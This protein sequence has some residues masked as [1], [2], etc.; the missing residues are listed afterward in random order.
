ME[1]TCAKHAFRVRACRFSVRS[2]SFLDVF[3]FLLRPAQ[4]NVRSI[5]TKHALPNQAISDFILIRS[6]SMTS[7]RFLGVR[8]RTFVCCFAFI[9]F[10]CLFARHVKCKPPPEVWFANA[11]GHFP[12][13]PAR[14]GTPKLRLQ[15]PPNTG[16]DAPETSSQ[17]SNGNSP[18]PLDVRVENASDSFFDLPR[19]L[20]DA[21]FDLL[22]TTRTIIGVI[23][24]NHILVR[25]EGVVD[26]VIENAAPKVGDDM[27]QFW[28][29]YD[30]ILVVYKSFLR[31]C[32]IAKDG[33]EVV[34]ERTIPAGASYYHFSFRGARNRPTVLRLIELAAYGAE[35][36]MMEKE[37]ADIEKSKH[38]IVNSMT[39][40]LFTPLMV[41]DTSVDEISKDI[42]RLRVAFNVHEETIEAYLQAQISLTQTN[43]GM[44]HLHE[45][46]KARN[47]LQEINKRIDRFA[48]GF[49]VHLRTVSTQTAELRQKILNMLA[50]SDICANKFSI[51]MKDKVNL[52]EL[53]NDAHLVF[54]P[55]ALR[56]GVELETSLDAGQFN[57]YI[58][59]DAVRFK[60]AL[61]AVLQN[62]VQFSY[63]N[64][65]PIRFDFQMDEAGGILFTVTDFGCGI[66]KDHINMVCEAFFAHHPLRANEQ[67]LG[68]GLFLTRTF[69]EAMGGQLKVESEEGVST[70]V[71]I[72][73]PLRLIAT[74]RV[75]YRSTKPECDPRRKS[76]FEPRMTD[77]AVAAAAPHADALATLMGFTVPANG[78]PAQEQQHSVKTYSEM[79]EMYDTVL[80]SE[81]NA[82]AGKALKRF[83]E[84]EGYK[85]E[86]Y[87]T[88][89]EALTRFRDM[90]TKFFAACLDHFTP[91]S[92]LTGA[93]I[94]AALQKIDAKL[95][96]VIITANVNEKVRQD[97]SDAGI[98]YFMEKPFNRQLLA[99]WLKDFSERRMLKE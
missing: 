58:Q 19:L 91:P 4:R 85:T 14:F 78:P 8:A 10:V 43:D 69:V 94:G 45:V 76:L 67:S 31:H 96:I 66:S 89:E 53:C 57:P 95:P 87:K 28:A 42:R 1:W 39:H 15:G 98:E 75:Q 79:M 6:E 37:K 23:D 92:A 9:S 27:L 22:A 13:P 88:G 70:R 20:Q 59:I 62:A 54:G 34:A 50:Y 83:I 93:E 5:K 60:Q 82:I 99:S 84:K 61:F 18:F 63:E 36:A 47:S 65:Q 74:H 72:T 24:T 2:E 11:V 64:G 90:P 35:Q 97:V 33:E 56:K 40:N 16:S 68:L 49:D 7:L 25:W 52:L 21:S 86:L 32:K 41:L 46:F 44:E 29:A 77:T 81:D 55:S 26:Y 80:L 3:I 38:T 71:Y 17:T 30:D 12:D 48:R 73:L 51:R